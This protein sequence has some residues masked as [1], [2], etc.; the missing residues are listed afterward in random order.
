MKYVPAVLLGAAFSATLTLASADEAKDLKKV[1][2]DQ[3]IYVETAK[4]GIVLSGYVDAG[5]TY[6]FAG[7]GVRD[8]GLGTAINRNPN[9]AKAGSD[10]NLNAFKLSLEKPLSTQN[11]FSAGF[12]ADLIY[13]QDANLDGNANRVGAPG[14]LTTSSSDFWLEQAYVQLRAPYGNGIDWKVGKFVTPLGYEVVERPANANITY[15]N[16]FRNM[17]PVDHTGILGSYKFNDIVDVKGGVVNGW[18]SD[19]AF[20]GSNG[21]TGAGL[22]ATINFT[23]PGGN[24]NLQNGAYVGLNNGDGSSAANVL[25]NPAG[26]TTNDALWVYDVWGQWKPKFANDKLTLGF[27]GD[28]GSYATTVLGAGTNDTMW[29]GAALYAKYQFTKIFSLATRTD[30]IHSDDGQKFGANSVGGV[31][32]PAAEDLYSF[33]VTGSFDLWE[34]VLLRAEYRLDY[35]QNVNY[36]SNTPGGTSTL[37]TTGTTNGP[38]HLID[39]QVVY[40]F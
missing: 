1:I 12:R 34:N 3:G 8:A 38:S 4:P 18:N 31:Y 30:W 24:A 14:T 28:V 13:G 11:D 27:N 5:Y 37:T 9:D 25:A 35:G 23:A 2:E 33:T 26:T 39:L 40:S 29:T 16:L 32:V 36:T 21:T 15:G 20:N 17:I 22:L 19:N 10:F 7:S 6:G